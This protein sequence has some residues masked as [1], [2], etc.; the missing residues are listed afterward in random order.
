MKKINILFVI[1]GV[2]ILISALLLVYL[3]LF[4]QKVIL[5]GGSS[6]IYPIATESARIFIG[7]NP[8][9]DIKVSS[10]DSSQ[11]IDDLINKKIHLAC[12]SRPLKEEEVVLS[13]KKGKYLDSRV[14]GYDAIVI[15]TH[16][17]NPLEDIR[18]NQIRK[19]FFKGEN[20]KQWSELGVNN[21]GEIS[22]YC[23]DPEYSGTAVFFIKKVIENG[24]FIKDNECIES[25][26]EIAKAVGED[27]N[28]IGFSSLKYA[29]EEPNIKILSVEGINHSKEN[30]AE[31][32]YVFSRNL[33]IVFDRSSSPL[34]KKLISFMLSDEGQKIVKEKGYLPLEEK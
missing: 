29:L 30:I 25:S 34:V 31:G 3:F 12:S 11:G 26:S 5:I 22:V 18:I 10:T 23:A 21:L 8:E 32:R 7:K 2:I 27:V 16:K 15:V 28:G 1:V 20:I 6:T 24:E 4:K 9:I 33:F 19:I 14:I 13:G 17:D